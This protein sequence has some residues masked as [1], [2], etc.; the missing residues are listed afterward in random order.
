MNTGDLETTP[1]PEPEN[2]SELPRRLFLRLGAAGAGGLAIAGAGGLGTPYLA[3]RGLLSTDGAFAATSTA[4]GDILFYTEVFPTSPLILEPF[5]D[6]LN[7]PKALAPSADF[8]T[9]DK[10]PGPGQGQQNSL[11]QRAPPD[12]AQPDRRAWTRSSTRSTCWCDR[13]RSPRPR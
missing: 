2:A 8:K 1:G 5:R 4:L 13:T 10:P 9:W 12:L 7:V 3:Q 6:E 11:R